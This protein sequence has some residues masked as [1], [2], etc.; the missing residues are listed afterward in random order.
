V[1]PCGTAP[2]LHTLRSIL[3]PLTHPQTHS[4][5]WL[6]E[7]YRQIIEQV[8]DYAIFT[9]D[10]EGRVITWNKGAQ[11]ILGFSEEEALG[12]PSSFIFTP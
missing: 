5:D 4:T 8:E 3:W 12:Q 1:S 6:D 10:N 11:R 9:F 7:R 2:S